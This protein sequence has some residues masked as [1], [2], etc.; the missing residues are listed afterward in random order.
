MHGKQP[1]PEI[2]SALEAFTSDPTPYLLP[3][4]DL[5]LRKLAAELQLLPVILDMGGCMSWPE[6]AQLFAIRK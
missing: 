1:I 6:I 2:T 5:D 3:G 4:D